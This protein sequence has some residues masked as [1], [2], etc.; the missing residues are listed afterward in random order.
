MTILQIDS[1]EKY[2]LSFCRIITIIIILLCLSASFEYFNRY[3]FNFIEFDWL[4]MY[5]KNNTYIVRSC[6]SFNKKY[7]I[8][9]VD[10]TKAYPNT[11]CIKIT[12]SITDSV[13]PVLLLAHNL[14][15]IKFNIIQ[16]CDLNIF[17]GQC[18]DMSYFEKYIPPKH[19]NVRHIQYAIF[20]AGWH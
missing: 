8:N 15:S 18:E 3:S 10:F 9:Y 2:D 20:F 6:N 1:N 16:N 17:K 7:L 14:Y 5:N 13:Q 19:K 4:S 12:F 11:T